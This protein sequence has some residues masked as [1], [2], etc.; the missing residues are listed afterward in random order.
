MVWKINVLNGFLQ[1]EIFDML[2]VESLVIPKRV[3]VG[4]QE[5]ST[6]SLLC[7]RM[8]TVCVTAKL[9]C[10]FDRASPARKMVIM[11]F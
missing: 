1:N 11:Q 7:S 9:G 4:E 5:S 8:K 10:S 6:T 3:Q 2:L